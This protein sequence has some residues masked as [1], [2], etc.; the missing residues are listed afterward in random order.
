MSATNCHSQ[1]RSQSKAVFSEGAHMA[2]ALSRPAAAYL[3]TS[4]AKRDG[5]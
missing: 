2:M 4:S 1:G 5:T 3:F